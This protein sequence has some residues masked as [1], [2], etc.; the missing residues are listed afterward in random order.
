MRNP[1]KTV[2]TKQG[3]TFSTTEY[4]HILTMYS[5][6][7]LSLPR[8]LKAGRQAGAKFNNRHKSYPM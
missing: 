5:I 6:M 2:S 1:V 3:T 7:L 4:S 8:Q